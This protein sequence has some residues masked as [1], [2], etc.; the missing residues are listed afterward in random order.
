MRVN[1]Q[2]IPKAPTPLKP[3]S[4]GV[5]QRKCACGG[6]SGVEGECE[7]C[8]RQNLSVRRSTRNSALETP[9][10][11]G[12]PPSVHEVLRSPGQPLDAG[13]R[14]FMEPRFGHDFSR[15]RLYTDARAAESARELNA[16]A[17]T[18]GNKIV[19]GQGHY[20]PTTLAGKKLLAHEL[21]HVVQQAPG[22]ARDV[23]ETI[24]VGPFATGGGAGRGTTFQPLR[25]RVPRTPD[26]S[27]PPVPEPERTPPATCPSAT[28]VVTDLR[29][30]D[31]SSQTETAMQR[32]INLG[33]S[34]AG[35]VITET[36]AMLQQADRA[37]RA[38][39]GSLLPAGRNF[40]APSSV[41]VRTPADFAQL[42]IP[43][44]AAAASRIGSVALETVPDFL[45]GLCITS[46][47]DPVL[48]REVVAPLLT[49]H[50]LDF[51]REYE[52]TRIGG[53]T[54]YPPTGAPFRPHVDIPS[55]S[56]NM[57]HVIVHEA[58]H[59]YVN[60]T[61]FNAASNSPVSH[62]LLEGGAEFL[63]RHVINQ[64]LSSDPN[65]HIGTGVYAGEFSYIA[66]S[67]GSSII[68]FPRAYFQGRIDLLG[69]TPA[70]GSAPTPGPAPAPGVRPKLA[71]G[72]AN[73][74]AEYE[75][76]RMAELVTRE[77]STLIERDS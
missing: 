51:V 1:L 35:R 75:A 47:D 66:N 49:R 48:Q 71:V 70:P 9:N 58:I 57:G 18:V 36:P 42:R 65:F 28:D 39:F 15:V 45:N 14:N 12:V 26:I 41:T 30:R 67:L 38:E 5:L 55:E 11:E 73:D 23:D 17:Y 72:Q 34:L 29:A 53:Q 60:E 37:I 3:L 13:T 32:E 6:A 2:A 19:M 50:N 59:F 77:P 63:A 22:I 69:L 76:D 7:G 40:V 43:D 44:A 54:S 16:L 52:R 56:R 25:P 21:T 61:Y 27:P 64:R 62:Q 68:S 4:Y 20:S 24:P 46:P 33:R 8:S 74:K 10:V 31:V